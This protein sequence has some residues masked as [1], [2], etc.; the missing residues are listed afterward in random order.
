MRKNFYLLVLLTGLMLSL[1]GCSKDDTSEVEFKVEGNWV[2]KKVNFLTEAAKWNDS[3]P[4]T[5]ANLRNYAPYMF[6]PMSG[7]QFL[8]K[9]IKSG[10]NFLGRKM[11]YVNNHKESQFHPHPASMDVWYWNYTD[12]NKGFKISS[13]A[14]GFPSVAFDMTTDNVV[15]D[16]NNPNIITFQT[17]VRSAKIGGEKDTYVVL[18]VEITMERGNAGDDMVVFIQGE[19][20]NRLP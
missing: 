3:I 4:Y 13:I 7:M 12:D 10:D 5:S 16:A 6:I 18:P 2:F 20:F 9:E 15:I 8:A 14:P 19:P 11:N 1:T 17:K